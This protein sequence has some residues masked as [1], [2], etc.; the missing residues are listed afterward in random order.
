MA[1]PFLCTCLI[2]RVLA[3]CGFA[4][5]V[6][7]SGAHLMVYDYVE[8]FGVQRRPSLC[9]AVVSLGTSALVLRSST[10]AAE[11]LLWFEGLRSAIDSF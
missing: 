11:R 7:L 1:L 6:L 10:S 2:A 4:Q 9:L 8:M 3:A 5:C